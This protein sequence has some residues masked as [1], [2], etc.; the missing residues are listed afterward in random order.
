[1]LNAAAALVVGG[2]AADLESGVAAAAQS[3]D[4]G[5]ALLKLDALIDYSQRAAA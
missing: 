5:T 3:I 4:N 2:G 1:V